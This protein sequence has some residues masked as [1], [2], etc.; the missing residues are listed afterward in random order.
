MISGKTLKFDSSK[1]KQSFY[2]ACNCILSNSNSSDQIVRLHLQELYC[3]PILSYAAV[4]SNYTKVQLN[5]LNAAWNA[6][7]RRIFWNSSVGIG[8]I[9]Y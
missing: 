7:Y 6:V 5:E 1:L 3:L 4:A 8:Q 9:F 2:A